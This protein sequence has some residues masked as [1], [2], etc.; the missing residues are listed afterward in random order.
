MI[1]PLSRFRPSFYVFYKRN[2][3]CG[4]CY[5]LGTAQ[6]QDAC[7][8]LEQKTFQS[9]FPP[10]LSVV[11]RPSAGLVGM[12]VDRSSFSLTAPSLARLDDDTA[13]MPL[14]FQ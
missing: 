1:S 11:P 6:D 13:E 2:L 4:K 5:L 12:P 10:T 8:P 3:E 7:D 9:C 14:L